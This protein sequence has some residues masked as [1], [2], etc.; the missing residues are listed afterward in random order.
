MSEYAK[1]MKYS[2]EAVSTLYGLSNV[3]LVISE[4]ADLLTRQEYVDILSTISIRLDAMA[5]EVSE[6]KAII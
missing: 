3:F 6:G 5:K 2:V 1:K 4:N